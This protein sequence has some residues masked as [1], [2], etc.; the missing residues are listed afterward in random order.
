[1]CLTVSHFDGIAREER[2]VASDGE[3]GL[4][5]FA[6]TNAIPVRQGRCSGES[7]ERRAAAR[8]VVQRVR[9][10]EF[11]NRMLQEKNQLR[12]KACGLVRGFPLLYSKFIRE[13]F[14]G[15]TR[16]EAPPAGY[17]TPGEVTGSNVIVDKQLLNP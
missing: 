11:D 1:M 12:E 2:W 10:H 7:C 16:A 13:E 8:D 6:F 4:D 15:Q 17:E 5:W 9:F 14:Y 3:F